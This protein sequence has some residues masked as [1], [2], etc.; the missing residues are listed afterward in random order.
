MGEMRSTIP[1]VEVSE[2]VFNN[3]FTAS[4][5]RPVLVGLLCLHLT[6]MG[7]GSPWFA[8]MPD[9]VAEDAE[10]ES[11]EKDKAADAGSE[12][13]SDEGEEKA[14]AGEEKAEEGEAA[15]PEGEE[16]AAEGEEKAEEGEEAAPEGEEK[17]AEG[18]EKAEVNEESASEGEEK[19]AEGEEKSDESEE[20]AADGEEKAEGEGKSEGDKSE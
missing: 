16:K 20:K 2:M 4:A 12:E 9:A 17:S 6:V 1:L 11:T 7:I 14:D 15:V 18:E 8:G 13:K 3:K 19:A 10:A 5:G